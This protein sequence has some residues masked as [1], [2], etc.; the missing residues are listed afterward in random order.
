[1]NHSTGISN[2]GGGSKVVAP[3]PGPLNSSMLN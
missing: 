1:M 2:G 3:E